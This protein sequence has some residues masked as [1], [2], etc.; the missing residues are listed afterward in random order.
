MR[1]Q[2]RLE[3]GRA[4]RSIVVRLLVDENLPTPAA[5][6]ARALR[7]EPP[8][9]VQRGRSSSSTLFSSAAGATSTLDS[10]GAVRRGCGRAALLLRRLLLLFLA[11]WPAQTSPQ[12][13][14]SSS[15]SSSAA[16]SLRRCLLFCQSFCWPAA[17]SSFSS[18]FVESSQ[19]EVR[20][21]TGAVGSVFAYGR[22]RVRHPTPG[23]SRARSLE[24][25]S[26]TGRRGGIE[27]R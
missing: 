14:A 8:R 25:S 22:Q 13:A 1:R 20:R 15:R 12:A 6:A 11:R 19:R 9:E 5:A 3:R 16:A 7:D 23:S 17:A 21:Q 26:A 10:S 4:G 2:G 27:A 24:R 18:R